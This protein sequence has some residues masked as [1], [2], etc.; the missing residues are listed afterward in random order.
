M[1]N[2]EDDKMKTCPVC[3]KRFLPAPYH[4]YKVYMNVTEAK[5]VGLCGNTNYTVC[6]W[7][8]VRAHEKK[9]MKG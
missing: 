9:H 8:C 1:I 5:K 4:A 7:H 3:G 6:S 2:V